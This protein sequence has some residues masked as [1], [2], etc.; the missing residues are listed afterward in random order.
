MYIVLQYLL[1]V[2][3]CVCIY[4]VYIVLQY[5]LH[6][7]ACVFMCI[8]EPDAHVGTIV[9][10]SCVCVCVYVL[11]GFKC[12]SALLCVQVIPVEVVYYGWGGGAKVCGV[13]YCVCS[14]Y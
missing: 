10:S 3:A 1:H 13:R 2:S 8:P 9:R 4:C 7:S 11:D 5:L 14:S 6:V 12:L